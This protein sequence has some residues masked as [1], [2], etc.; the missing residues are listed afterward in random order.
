ML[1]EFF[2]LLCSCLFVTEGSH[3]CEKGN[4]INVKQGKELTLVSSVEPL[5]RC[6]IVFTDNHSSD[7]CCFYENGFSKDCENSE[8][9]KNRKNTK[10]PDYILTVDNVETK[11][12]NLTIKNVSEAAAGEYRS[13]CA[14]HKPIQECM[15][16]VSGPP[17]GGISGPIVGFIFALLLVLAPALALVVA[18]FWKKRRRDEEQQL[19]GSEESI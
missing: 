6:H 14:D 16:R 9:Y 12:C 1:L 10:C 17:G 11:T 5:E 3:N 15:V 4:V 8:E 7:Q 13:Y 2:V 18:D 19:E